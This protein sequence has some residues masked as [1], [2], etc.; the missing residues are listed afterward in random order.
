MK[1]KKKKVNPS[2]QVHYAPK[3][4]KKPYKKLPKGK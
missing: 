1:M 4:G 2:K 3:K